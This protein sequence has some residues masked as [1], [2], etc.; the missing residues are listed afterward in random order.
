ML[1]K[2]SVRDAIA[3]LPNKVDS[4]LEEDSSLSKGQGLI[5]LIMKRF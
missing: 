3:I 5:N 1:S 2:V 4:T